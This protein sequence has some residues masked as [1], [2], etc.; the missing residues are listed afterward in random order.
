MQILE[1]GLSKADGRLEAAFGLRQH[2]NAA[3]PLVKRMGIAGSN[4]TLPAVQ[5]AIVEAIRAAG[6]SEAEAA[7]ATINS[8]ARSGDVRAAVKT[9]FVELRRAS[10]AGSNLLMA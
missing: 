10:D 3:R 2:G 7:L 4:E 6:G 9:G 8:N 1:A 5:I